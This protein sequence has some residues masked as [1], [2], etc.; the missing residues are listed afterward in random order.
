MHPDKPVE[1]IS[2]GN[3]NALSGR[4]G[5]NVLIAKEDIAHMYVPVFY[6]AA[7]KIIVV[8]DEV[9]H[10]HLFAAKAQHL[11]DNRAMVLLP[12][13]PPLQQRHVNK[14]AV[15]EQVLKLIVFKHLEQL[16]GLA[17]GVAKVDIADEQG[18]NLH[19]KRVW[20]GAK[21]FA[22]RCIARLG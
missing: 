17:I 7:D 14:V 12:E 2:V 6:Q 1:A 22:A 8:A 5:V 20:V 3:K 4:G 21:L 10:L 9:H 13:E 19:E 18:A 16:A 15:D 11:L